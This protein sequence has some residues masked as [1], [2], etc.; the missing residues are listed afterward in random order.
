MDTRLYSQD[1][2]AESMSVRIFLLRAVRL[3]RLHK[4][5]DGLSEKVRKGEWRMPRLIQAMKDVISCDKR[6]VGANNP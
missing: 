6:R 2:T 5:N 3:D 4:A 1:N